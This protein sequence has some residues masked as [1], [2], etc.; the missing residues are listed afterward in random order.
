MHRRHHTGE[1]VETHMWAR[2]LIP[3]TTSSPRTTISHRVFA[4][5]PLRRMLFLLRM[6]PA[7][8]PSPASDAAVQN[9]GDDTDAA[10]LV[11]H[12]FEGGNACLQTS[13]FTVA[14]AFAGRGVK[15]YTAS[16]APDAS[17]E[18]LR[19][20]PK[21]RHAGKK[22]AS[23]FSFS[24]SE[25]SPEVSFSSPEIPVS[26]LHRPTTEPTMVSGGED[27]SASA[28]DPSSTSTK[29][30]ATRTLHGFSAAN[31]SAK[32]VQRR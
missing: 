13:A 10:P 4:A 23:S 29:T 21:P 3:S 12:S 20:K 5:L 28:P 27:E 14:S 24:V 22:N 30:S 7:P 2:L 19:I 11:R 6:T 8:V 16:V 1:D 26:T 25:V 15:R 31:R 9:G 18:T 17:D 32:N